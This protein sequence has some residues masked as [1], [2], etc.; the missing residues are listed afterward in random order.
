M[1]IR[2]YR[3]FS[4]SQSTVNQ[5][6]LH[7]LLLQPSMQTLLT[8]LNSITNDGNYIWTQDDKH[9]LES[10]LIL[11]TSQPLCLNPNPLVSILKNKIS[12]YKYVMSE[13]DLKKFAYK[14]SQAHLN[15]SARWNEFKLPYP[16]NILKIRKKHLGALQNE[17]IRLQSASSQT[18][19]TEL[20]CQK[21]LSSIL[22]SSSSFNVNELNHFKL[23]RILLLIKSIFRL[24]ITGRK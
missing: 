4:D 10:Q 12:S 5:Y 8:D 20:K 16:F 21:N 2:D 18:K 23:F 11:A 3:R 6:D 13:R 9:A 15:R 24:L 7:F 19:T 22:M 14:Y 17:F 1:E